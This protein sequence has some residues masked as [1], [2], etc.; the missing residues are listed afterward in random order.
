MMLN[1]NEMEILECFF[2]ELKDKT[3]KE[4]EVLSRKDHETTFRLLKA[5]VKKKLLKEKKAGKTNV[6][7]F[8]SD[9]P[10][11]TLTLTIFVN[12]ITRRRLQFKDKH[13]LIYRRLYEFLNEIKLE[14]FGI[15]ILFGS[16]AKGSETKNSDVDLLCV[17]NKKNVREIAQTF[18]TKYNLNIQAVTVKLSDFKNIKTDNPVFWSDLL[19]YGIVLEGLDYVFKEAYRND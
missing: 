19:T 6:Y 10:D 8:V 17:T 1:Q 3:T 18:R 7:E 11:Y 2:P 4:I 9:K 15:A 14:P 5:L 13:F 16:F 12:Y